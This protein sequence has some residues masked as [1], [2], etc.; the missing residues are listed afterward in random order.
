MPAKSL[1]LFITASVAPSLILALLANY[2]VRRYAARWG[3]I[4]QPGERKRHTTP[5]PR[6]GG[7]AIWLGVIGTFALGM[8]A[9]WLADRVPALKAMV[10]DFAQP[11]L[12][13]IWSQVG[14]LWLLLA[15]GSV[16]M[17]L[18]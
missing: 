17:L 15:A 3:L 6:G 9:L 11:H 18:G 12:A 2:V 16:L 7:L 13:G 14:K 10:P 4:D 8:L 5:K 1:L